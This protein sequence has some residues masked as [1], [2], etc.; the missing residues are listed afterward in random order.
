MQDQD[1]PFLRRS[2]YYTCLAPY[3][4]AYPRDQICVVRFEDLVSETAPGWRQVLHQFGL[5]NRPAPRTAHNVSS[6]RAH[7]TKAMRWL[8][9]SRFRSYIPAVPQ[10]LRRAGSRLLLRSGPRHRSRL[11][12]SVVAIPEHLL[13]PIWRDVERLELW[14]GA[15]E[16]LWERPARAGGGG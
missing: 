8:W 11:D 5:A 12:A 3:V 4:S 9:T 15:E 7:Y 1:N 14:L 2:L 10:P 13:Q 6:E 16:P